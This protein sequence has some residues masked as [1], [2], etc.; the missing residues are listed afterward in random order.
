MDDINCAK[1]EFYSHWDV[2]RTDL[3]V[4]RIYVDLAH[5]DVHDDNIDVEVEFADGRRYGATFFTPQNIS[6]LMQQ[7]KST[8]DEAGNNGLYFWCVDMVI[9]S[10]LTLEVIAETVE[11]LVQK[12]ELEHAFQKL[13]AVVIDEEGCEPLDDSS[14]RI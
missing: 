8:V 1:N 3:Y 14:G 2:V 13:E 7:R 11:H 9:V 4:I 10:Q 5:V 6:R 12:G